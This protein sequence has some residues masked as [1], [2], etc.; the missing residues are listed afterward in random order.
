MYVANGHNHQCSKSKD[1]LG[2]EGYQ[3]YSWSARQG[4]LRFTCSCS[5]LRIWSCETVFAVPS[6]VS[7]P[8]SIVR[9]N[10]VLTYGIPPEFRVQTS[11]PCLESLRPCHLLVL[12]APVGEHIVLTTLLG[13]TL[14]GGHKIVGQTKPQGR[15]VRAVKGRQTKR[16]TS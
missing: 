4:K 7:L 16:G 10:Q 8:I 15:D 5:C 1:Q 14:L 6:S 2:K 13:S 11:S 9:L 3:S 12:T